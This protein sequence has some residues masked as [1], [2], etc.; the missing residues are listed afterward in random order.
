MRSSQPSPLGAVET[1]PSVRR[2]VCGSAVASVRRPVATGNSWPEAIERKK[3][4]PSVAAR[5]A[6]SSPASH[7]ALP[8][9]FARTR[10]SYRAV[11]AQHYFPMFPRPWENPPVQAPKTA[12]CA[13]PTASRPASRPCGYR[14]CNATVATRAESPR[15]PL[16]ARRHPDNPGPSSSR[17]SRGSPPKERSET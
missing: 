9:G 17:A 14:K 8:S 1:P 6:G 16:R 3:P 5:S 4:R 12:G 11:L 13:A 15:R 7:P 10:R 2:V